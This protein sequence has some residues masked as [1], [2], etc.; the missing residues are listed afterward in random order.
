MDAHVRGFGYTNE[1]LSVFKDTYFGESRYVRFQADGG[2]IFNRVFF[3][4]VDQFWL[5]NNGN[6]NFGHTGS[7]CNI[8]RRIQLGLQIFF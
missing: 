8:P 1:D 3:C 4:P 7:Q 2:N 5:A 6:S